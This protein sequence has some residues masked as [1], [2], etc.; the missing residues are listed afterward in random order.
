MGADDE[1]AELFSQIRN[2][3]GEADTLQ[4]LNRIQ[5]HIGAAQARAFGK[6]MTM[7]N[8][9]WDVSLLLLLWKKKSAEGDLGRD[10]LTRAK[11]AATVFNDT[12][13]LGLCLDLVMLAI[14]KNDKQFFVDFGKCLS[15]DISPELFSK[16]ERDVAEIVLQLDEH[17]GMPTSAGVYELHKRAQRND[18]GEF[19]ELKIEAT[20]G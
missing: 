20:Q 15:G 9:K 6:V 3:L 2:A 12:K 19:A 18:R 14:R 13:S 7:S 4:V 11:L 16:Y 17:P 10:S 1:T 5:A 8:P